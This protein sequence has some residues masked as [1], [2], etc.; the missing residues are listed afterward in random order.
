SPYH[1]R[2]GRLYLG[3]KVSSVNCAFVRTSRHPVRSMPFRHSSYSMVDPLSGILISTFVASPHL[4]GLTTSSTKNCA[5]SVYW[6]P[7]V[8]MML[9]CVETRNSSSTIEWTV[10]AG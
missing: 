7:R 9:L 10:L 2:S 6:R 5:A 1:G 8:L 3:Q 4:H